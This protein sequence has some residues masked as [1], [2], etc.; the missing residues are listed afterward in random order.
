MGENKKFQR[1]GRR[2][3][4]KG[5]VYQLYEDELILPDKRKVYY[6]HVEHMGAAAVL[7][8]CRKLPG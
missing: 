8:V 3:V 4:G 6:D 7:P 2:M 5:H 1:I